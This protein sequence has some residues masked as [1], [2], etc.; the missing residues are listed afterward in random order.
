VY[1]LLKNVGGRQHEHNKLKR[2]LE[3]LHSEYVNKPREFFELKLKSYEKQKSLFKK[4]LSVNEKALIASY[5]VSYK[6]A[7]CKK[8]HT[9]GE[10]LILPAAI[11]IVEIM[12]ED[13]FV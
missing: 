12:F 5:K 13:N 7:R 2:H 6:I 3:T 9:I 4:T 1:H 8:P 10:E 11:E